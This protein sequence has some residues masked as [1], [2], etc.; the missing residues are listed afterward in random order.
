MDEVKGFEKEL[1]NLL[2]GKK[3]INVRFMTKKEAQGSGWDKKPLC[4]FLDDNSVLIP[5]SDDEGND[6]G[7]LGYILKDDYMTI[8]TVW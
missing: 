6:G 5:Q 4:I 1:K 8:G 7:A 2:V 3:I